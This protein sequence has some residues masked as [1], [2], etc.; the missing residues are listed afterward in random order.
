MAEMVSER[1]GLLNPKSSGKKMPV[2]F[3]FFDSH[4]GSRFVPP[5]HGIFFIRDES[6]FNFFFRKLFFD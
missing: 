2:F 6:S 1:T 3:F 5:G 4:D